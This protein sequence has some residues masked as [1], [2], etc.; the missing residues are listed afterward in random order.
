MHRSSQNS[1]KQICG[2][3]L[4]W[5]DNRRW[6]CSLE[7]VLL[8]I[9]DNFLAR[10]NSLKL[11][12]LNDG[13]VSYKRANF[14]LLTDGLEWCELLVD[15]CDVFISCLDSHSDG[16]HSLQRIHWWATDVMIHFSKS[17]TNSSTSWMA[18]GWV[19]FQQNFIFGWTISLTLILLCFCFNNL[20]NIFI[21]DSP[22]IFEVE[23]GILNV[24]GNNLLFSIWK[25]FQLQYV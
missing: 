6:S 17:E 11:K 25:Y 15:Y 21:F 13:F 9:M 19:N 12:H 3:I 2:W 7:E 1:S 16:T 10:S 22:R 20:F 14:H 18:W 4:M 24:K 23:K 5:E 8:W